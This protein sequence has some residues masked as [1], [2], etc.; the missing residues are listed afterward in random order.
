MLEKAH[1][2][3]GKVVCGKCINILRPRPKVNYLHIAK[4]VMAKA[5]DARE[6]NAKLARDARARSTEFAAAKEDARYEKAKRRVIFF[7][8]G[9]VTLFWVVVLLH[10]GALIL[11]FM[12]MRSWLS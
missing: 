12:G 10:V 8:N 2:Y 9:C 11:F 7:L 5:W 6:V 4:N 1:L 3:E